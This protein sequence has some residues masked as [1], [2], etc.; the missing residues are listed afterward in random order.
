MYFFGA[1]LFFIA[2][3]CLL[4]ERKSKRHMFAR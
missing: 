1:A 4:G 3:A 2:L